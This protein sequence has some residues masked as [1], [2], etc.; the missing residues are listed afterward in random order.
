MH[1]RPL[2]PSA[3]TRYFSLLCLVDVLLVMYVDCVIVCLRYCLCMLG[4]Y[5]VYLF[6]RYFSWEPGGG[7]RGCAN[8]KA[9]TRQPSFAKRSTDNAIWVA[10]LV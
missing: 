4:L 7:C 1:M 3:T 5:V 2:Q 6:S 10:R 8:G 9:H